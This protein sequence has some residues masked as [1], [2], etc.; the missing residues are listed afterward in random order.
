M[1]FT[2]PPRTPLPPIPI[3]QVHKCKHPDSYATITQTAIQKAAI[4]RSRIRFTFWY[5]LSRSTRV[6]RC[7]SGTFAGRYA[8]LQPTNHRRRPFAS[9]RHE[10]R[11]RHATKS[12]N[13]AITAEASQLREVETCPSRNSFTTIKPR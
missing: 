5:H 12:A 7:D 10:R 9:A 13:P 6:E 8:A 2:M 1:A 3:A 4:A 11:A